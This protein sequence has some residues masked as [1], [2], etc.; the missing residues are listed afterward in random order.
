MLKIAADLMFEHGAAATSIDDVKRAAKVSAA[1]VGYYFGDKQSLVR[2]V[3]EYQAETLIEG[4]RPLLDRLDNFEALYAWRDHVVAMRMERQYIRGCPVGSLAS[5]LADSSPALR[6]D[7][8]AAFLRWRE[9]ITAGLTAMR[10]RGDLRPEADPEAL[11]MALLAA[12]EGGTLL[13]QT[14]RQAAPLEAVLDAVL[15]HVHSLA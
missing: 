8:A 7:I 15:A 14:L 1:K 4:Q 12:V 13:A 3:I 6:E 11:S 10:T 2:A 9:P 5:E